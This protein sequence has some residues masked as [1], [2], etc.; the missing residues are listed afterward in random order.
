MESHI[1]A[2]GLPVTVTLPYA[3]DIVTR[4][5]WLTPRTEEIPSGGGVQ[6]TNARHVLALRRDEVPSV[7]RGTIIVAPE[8]AGGADQ[9]WR[10]DGVESIEGDHYRVSLVLDS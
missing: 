4:G 2:F 10:V 9:T 7:P 6:K 5:I 8:Q 3:D 1:R